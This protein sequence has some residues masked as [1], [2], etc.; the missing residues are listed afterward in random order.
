MG[1]ILFAALA[2]F[3]WL[4]MPS[5]LLG[6]QH[7]PKSTRTPLKEMTRRAVFYDPRLDLV[8]VRHADRLSDWLSENGLEKL[9]SEELPGWMKARIKEGA[10]G[11]VVV[12][13]MGMAPATVNESA[14][15]DTL[16]YRYLNAGGRIVWLGDLPFNYTQRI[17]ARP[18]GP[19]A[20]FSLLGLKGGWG[21]PY[22]GQN[23]P[24][25]KTRAADE[26]G[27]EHV[28]GS[29]TGFAV[30]DVD[31]AF[32]AFEVPATKKIGA[33][34]FLKRVN[35]DYEWGGLIKMMQTYDGRWDW[36]LADVWRAA[37]YVGKK[38]EAPK[39][40]APYQPPPA[41]PLEIKMSGSGIDN[42][43]VFARGEI[44][45]VTV[46]GKGILDANSVVAELLQGEQVLTRIEEAPET[47]ESGSLDAVLSL[48]T[49]PYDFGDYMLR[50][51][52]VRADGPSE[53][54]SQK[55]FIRHVPE[56][57]FLWHIWLNVS[58]NPY[59]ADISLKDVKEH[60]MEPHTPST[61]AKAMDAIL[62][63]SIGFSAR[64]MP[65]RKDRKQ[66]DPGSNPEYFRHGIDRKVA[67][68]KAYGGGR[69]M[70]GIS[71]PEILKNV[72]SSMLRFKS[73]ANHPA[74]RPFILTNDDFS[75]YYGWDF[76]PHVLKRFKQETGLDAPKEKVKPPFGVVDE[77]N[78]WLQW[79][80]FTL[81]EVTG[82]FNR[83][84]TEAV[85]SV[86]KDARI[87]PIPGG[88]QIPLI[89]M[90]T[91]SQY[92]PLNFGEYGFNL[93]AFYYYNTYW[94]PVMTN[95]FWLEAGRMG[96]RDLPEWVMPD[97]FRTRGYLRNNLFHLLAGGADGLAYFTYD[98]RNEGTW[99]EAKHLAP[100]VEKIAPVQA[101][102]KPRRKIGLLHSITTNCFNEAYDLVLVYAYLNLVQA[103]FDIELVCEEEIM[104]GRADRYDAILLYNV[105]W[106]RR[107]VYDALADY[108]GKG[109]LLLLDTSVPFEVPG[110]KRLKVDLGMGKEKTTG[111]PPEGAHLST[112]GI[113]DYGHPERIRLI[114]GELSKFVK[115]LFLSDDIRLVGHTF[116]IDKVPYIWFVNAHTGKEYQLLHAWHGAGVPGAGTPEKV[117]ELKEWEKKEMA[118]GDFSAEAA[119]DRLPGVPYDLLRGKRLKVTE[120]NGRQCIR[121]AMERFGGTL[122]AFYPEPIKQVRIRA[123]QRAPRM[124]EVIFKISVEGASGPIPGAVPL[125]VSLIEP[126]GD[127]Y[128]TSG[129][130]ATENGVFNF[131]WRPAANAPTGTWTLKVTELA[132]EKKALKTITLR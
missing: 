24:V 19:A 31:I 125:K 49:S 9:R 13:T 98:H 28:D 46:Q 91:A 64:L 78:P 39:M 48:D 109:G 61:S 114:A 2:A 72:R 27:I 120:K 127:E 88:M 47:N 102:L 7:S 21:Q 51:T 85:T 95:T 37:N 110:A 20:T 71:H 79:C 53:S 32:G 35:P 40:P 12:M 118:K 68:N 6:Q 126:S 55:L 106:L 45:Q 124:E 90:W 123:P 56:R 1:K 107:K 43:T 38:V 113:N 97:I 111:V 76:A 18:G 34:S 104:K 3:L 83:V 30:E 50:L 132:S 42:R 99:G 128:I 86:R 121:A 33:T 63:H 73:F 59:R 66:Y 77:N 14:G 94:Q 82:K 54:V 92:P 70:L 74:L 57:S 112:P 117:A 84:Q 67:R 25:K 115:P 80:L 60:G 93:I 105:K 5:P 4:L 108:A 65:D 131:R 36:A 69:P 62:K 89:M 96:N 23:L 29:I 81:R 8:H 100:L 130:F 119:F 129:S 44:V 11:S 52:A 101:K 26:W 116:E 15:K 87:G 58:A 17:D 75:I 103:H 22:W 10:Y 122:I 41:P 16:W